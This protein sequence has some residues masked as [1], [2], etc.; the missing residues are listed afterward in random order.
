MIAVQPPDR[1]GFFMDKKE[2]LQRTEVIF[3][4]I[5]REGKIY[6]EGEDSS[7]IRKQTDE[8]WGTRTVTQII[9][10]R[11]HGGRVATD[12]SVAFTHE[13]L[14]NNTRTHSQRLRAGRNITLTDGTIARGI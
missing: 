13:P 11:V 5:E 10:G 1:G 3:V 2:L 4:P 14:A 9:S 8:G 12:V 7:P 6:Q